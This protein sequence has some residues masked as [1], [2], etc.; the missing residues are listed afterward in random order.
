VSSAVS[1]AVLK[2]TQSSIQLPEG[3]PYPIYP[4]HHSSQY[5]G[6]T[7]CLEVIEQNKEMIT[8]MITVMKAQVN[9]L[10][11]EVASSGNTHV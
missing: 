1:S 10:T 7:F 8:E 6:A 11:A 4:G 9:G 2:L 3:G 5:G